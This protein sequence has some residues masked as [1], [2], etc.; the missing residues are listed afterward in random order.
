MPINFP[1]SPA[2]NQTYTY[3]SRTWVW[4]G[5]GW[6][7]TSTTYGPQG[8]Q[9]VQGTQGTQGIQGI[10]G[11]SPT[12]SPTFTGTVTMPTGTTAVS[13]LVFPAGSLL[14]TPAAGAFEAD[15]LRLLY[16]TPN[17]SEG[18]GLVS[19]SH[20]V[21]GP[22][23]LSNVT[24]TQS[25]FGKGMN[26]TASTYIVEGVV[27]LT[28]LGTTSRSISINWTVNGGGSL[29]VCQMS[30]ILNTY[31][32]TTASNTTSNMTTGSSIT[33]TAV[34]VT[35]S[36]HTATDSAIYISGVIRVNAGSYNCTPL[37]TFGTAPGGTPTVTSASYLKF[38]PIG[39]QSVATIGS[40]S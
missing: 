28:T 29:G 2:L 27:Y 37:I 18:R 38:T 1:S 19:S 17:T 3:G 16:S 31:S 9:G 11:I 14:N 33:A 5:S 32:S 35:G 12:A 40:F 39:N 25:I 30:Y 10:Q 24:T 22:N 23:T 7:Q 13:P 8:I 6:Q 26:V 34:T 4:N 21:T 20:I 36:S 15:S